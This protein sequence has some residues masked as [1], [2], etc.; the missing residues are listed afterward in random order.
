VDSVLVI[1]DNLDENLLLAS[2]NLANVL[3]V[4]RVKQIQCRWCFSKK[5]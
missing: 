4:S 5:C 1:T 3:I 2:R